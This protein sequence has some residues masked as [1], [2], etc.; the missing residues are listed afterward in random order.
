MCD[1]GRQG[2]A[3]TNSRLLSRGGRI[4]VY[5]GDEKGIVSLLH[6]RGRWCAQSVGN[7]AIFPSRG[8]S[9]GLLDKYRDGATLDNREAGA[10]QWLYYDPPKFITM[11]TWHVEAHTM[12]VN[13]T[14]AF[15]C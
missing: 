4:I 7:V 1:G 13:T 14:W 5:L 9:C 6:T 15:A 10:R 2:A 8:S 11:Y 12:V 3:G